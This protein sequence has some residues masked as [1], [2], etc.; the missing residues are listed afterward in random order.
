[1]ACWSIVLNFFNKVYATQVLIIYIV[2]ERVAIARAFKL[3]LT[4]KVW[5]SLVIQEHVCQQ[6]ILASNQFNVHAR[7]PYLEHTA[8]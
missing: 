6:L 1:L 3:F 5:W 4:A 2:S 8:R 7:L